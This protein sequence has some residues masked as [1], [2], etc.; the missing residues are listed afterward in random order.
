MGLEGPITTA[1]LASIVASTSSVATGG[2]LKLRTTFRI[3][4]FPFAR[5][6]YSWKWIRPRS[7]ITWVVTSVSVIGSTVSRTPKRSQRILVALVSRMPFLQHLS[8]CNMDS[9]VPVPHRR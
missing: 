1:S 7:V 6:Q 4:I 3:S 9:T 8:P 5:I 2:S